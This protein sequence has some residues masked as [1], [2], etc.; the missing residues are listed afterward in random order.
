MHESHGTPPAGAVGTR[1]ALPATDHVLAELGSIYP[2]VAY[3]GVEE[4]GDEER[5]PV[6]EEQQAEQFDEAIF[7]GMVAMR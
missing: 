5:G 3:W 7:A 1:S 2:I 6:S 4:A